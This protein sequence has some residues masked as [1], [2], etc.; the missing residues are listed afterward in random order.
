MN[1][2]STGYAPPPPGFTPPPTPPAPPASRPGLRRATGDGAVL[3]GVAAGIARSLRID[4]V[5]V[6]VAFVV[7]T[8][9]GGS[10]LL[11][12]LAGWLFI[13]PEGRDDSAGERF[14]RNNNLLVITL[15]V[16][17]AVLV[18]GP[19][20]AWGWAGDGPGVGGAVLLVLVVVGVVLLLRRD[21]RPLSGADTP[22]PPAAVSDSGPPS[23]GDS[24]TPS[25]VSAQTAV[26]PVGAT[27]PAPP[28]APAPPAAV[29]PTRPPQPPRERS[30]LGRLTVGVALLVAGTLVALD[31]AD[32]IVVEPVVVLGSALAVVALGLLVGTLVGR[33]RGLIA[34]GIV[35]VFLLIPVGAA[36]EGLRVGGGAGERL[37]QPLSQS[38][39]S[40]RYE[41]GV[42]ELT[43]DLS[44]LDI[45]GTED[46][47][48]SV[49]M[50]E[51]IVLLP[52]DVG[53]DVDADVGAGTID[54]PTGG[55][56]QGGIG[57]EQ[58]WQREG[59]GSGTLNLTMSSGLGA[60][61]VIDETPL[62]GGR[63]VTR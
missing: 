50:G 51:V 55:P 4:P 22:S 19:M 30:V 37:Y 7:L 47:E 53:V 9:F 63:Q 52:P 34:L 35:L 15:G 62:A 33:A 25:Q 36:P 44:K 12:Y 43:V 11:L 23:G 60:V 8:I 17:V 38:E 21:E 45:V 61:T 1:E 24:P 20:V 40:D 49:G 28:S 41:L 48:V 58:S 13:P 54:F 46:V 39:L 59:D 6:R 16:V 27:P 2:N 26:L 18:I 5:L 3:G 31:V 14:F 42:G 29:E 10:G 57:L 32:V 56:E